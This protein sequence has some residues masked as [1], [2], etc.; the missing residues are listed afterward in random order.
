MEDPNHERT[1]YR[2]RYPE[3]NISEL[4]RHFGLSR[5]TIYR[6]LNRDSIPLH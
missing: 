2:T 1:T 3:A 6:W 4:A 5:K